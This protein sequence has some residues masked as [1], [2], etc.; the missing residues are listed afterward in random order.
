MKKG[1]SYSIASVV[2]LIICLIAFVLPSTLGSG[3]NPNKLP[4]F[5]K[6]NGKEIKYEQGSDFANYVSYY[7][8]TFQTRYRKI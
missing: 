2:I 3:Q 7:G 6:Y 1:L 8:Q 4:A 5:G